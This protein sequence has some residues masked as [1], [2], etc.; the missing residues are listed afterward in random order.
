MDCGCSWVL[1]GCLEGNLGLISWAWQGILVGIRRGK[2]Y[3]EFLMILG[4]LEQRHHR[5][6]M[7]Y[8]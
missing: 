3:E 4:V 6:L 7:E 5:D 2:V 1:V 8:V